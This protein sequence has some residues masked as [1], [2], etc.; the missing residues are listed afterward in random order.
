MPTISLASKLPTTTKPCIKNLTVENFGCCEEKQTESIQALT[1]PH[2]ESFNWFLNTGV[3]YIA[4][5]N[6]KIYKFAPL[7]YE[8]MRFI[9]EIFNCECQCMFKT[10]WADLVKA[11]RASFETSAVADQCFSVF[12]IQLNFSAYS[13]DPISG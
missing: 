3:K 1:R 2:V 8:I 12:N 10:K 7:H 11:A 4:K 13:S 6:L 5:V 9:R